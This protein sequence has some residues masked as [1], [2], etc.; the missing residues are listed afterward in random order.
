MSNEDF[1]IWAPYQ[2]FYIHAMLFNTT[3]ALQ[4]CYEAELIIQKISE[5]EID[6]QEMKDELLDYLQNVINH[7]GAISRYFFPARDGVKGNDSQKTI[8]KDRGQFLARVFEVKED[9]PLLNRGLRNSI[10]HFD[11]RLDLY[12][13]RAII[14]YIFPSLILHEPEDEGVPNHIFRA[15]YLNEGIY[16]V[17]G[18]RFEL[19]PIVE[20]VAR[21]HDLLIEFDSQGSLLRE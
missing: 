4:S 7:S 11:E 21:I 5:G 8:H 1:E 2:A 3:S 9:S 19:Q 10:E 18:E 14:G 6:L 13:Q 12:F 15:Y 17:L 20:E 16:Q